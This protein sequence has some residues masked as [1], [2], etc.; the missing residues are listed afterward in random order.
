MLP[1]SRILVP[2]DFSERCLDMMPYVRAM[3][4]QYKAEVILLHV[5]SPV[6]AVPPTGISGPTLIP[7]PQW[8][9]A[10]RTEDL[11]RFAA[12]ELEGLAVRRLVYQGHPEGQIC[13]S[14][15]AEDVQLVVM[16]THGY[17]LFRRFL[18]G[19]VTSKVL[20][21]VTC[22]VLTGVHSEAKESVAS[23]K[24]SNIVCAIDLSPHSRD[25]LTWASRLA[26]DF[27]AKLSTVH[28]VPSVSPGLYV[29]FSSNCKQELEDMARK[30]VEKL[31]TEVGADS[32]TIC[33]REGDVAREV[34]SFAQSIGADLLVVGRGAHEGTSGRLKT[35]AYAII[36][37]A[38][39]PV[40]SV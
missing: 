33:I 20:H 11:E 10:A 7:V 24:F 39:C 38:T 25:T 28:V 21:D 6:Y 22:P 15:Q 23:A 35:N 26:R 32:V 12:A 30:E 31:Q 17:G 14:T 16:A 9:F 8:V 2:V 37:Q 19:S 40:V 4:E 3:A 34:S 36:R 1:I 13:T 27:K 5:V 18:I 29:T